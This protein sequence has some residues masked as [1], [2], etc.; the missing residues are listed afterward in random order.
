[1]TRQ[2]TQNEDLV[3]QVG[4]EGVEGGA[5]EELNAGIMA[6]IEEVIMDTVM[7]NLSD[8]QFE[9]FKNAIADGGEKMEE[10]IAIVTAQ[11]PALKELIEDAVDSELKI[12]KELYSAT[13]K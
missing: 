10:R 4:V 9:E 8:E 3:S 13:Q 5:R 11:V 1:M 6:R 7:A 12:L 2:I